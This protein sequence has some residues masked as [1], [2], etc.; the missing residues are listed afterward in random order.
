MTFLKFLHPM[1]LFDSLHRLRK[2]SIGVDFG[3]WSTGLCLCEA[4]TCNPKIY[5]IL[6]PENWE[7]EYALSP[8]EQ[9]L[10]QGNEGGSH[11]RQG[12]FFPSLPFSPQ[13]LNAST[14]AVSEMRYVVNYFTPS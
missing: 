3:E 2:K 8:L 1:D 5:P 9:I 6:A 14:M 11:F 4:P 10:N 7:G 13:V 12:W